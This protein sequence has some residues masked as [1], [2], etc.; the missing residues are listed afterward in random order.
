LDSDAAWAAP[1]SLKEKI[2]TWRGVN[3][4]ARQET[5]IDEII[6]PCFGVKGPRREF[7]ITVGLRGGA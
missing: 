6:P 2:G 4:S 3:V 5:R 7:K 1:S